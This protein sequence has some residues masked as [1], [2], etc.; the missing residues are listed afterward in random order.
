MSSYKKKAKLNPEIQEDGRTATHSG[1]VYKHTHT[2]VHTSNTKNN[3]K[4]N[5]FP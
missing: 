2:H 3:F 4:M 1:I 5:I